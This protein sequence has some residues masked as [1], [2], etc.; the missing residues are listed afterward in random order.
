MDLDGLRVDHAG[1]DRAANDL[2]MIVTRIDARMHLL[3]D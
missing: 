1:L 3:D 2:R